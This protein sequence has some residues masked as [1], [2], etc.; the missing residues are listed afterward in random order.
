MG[1]VH[2][3]I[4][5]YRVQATGAVPTSM[6]LRCPAGTCYPRQVVYSA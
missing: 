4:N 2:D 5:C 6:S 3:V 1:A